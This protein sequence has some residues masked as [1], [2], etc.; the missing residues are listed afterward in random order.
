MIS[1]VSVSVMCAKIVSGGAGA[2]ASGNQC[3]SRMKIK[4]GAENI[5]KDMEYVSTSRWHARLRWL[6]RAVNHCCLQHKMKLS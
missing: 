3:E 2:R 4:I 1:C 6:A 5:N